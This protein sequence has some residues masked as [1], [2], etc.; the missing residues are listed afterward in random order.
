MLPAPEITT[1]IW[2]FAQFKT[3]YVNKSNIMII[4]AGH[5]WFHYQ[6][7]K[8]CFIWFYKYRYLIL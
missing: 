6:S 1:K 4:K 7:E 2:T 8:F 5:Y 3:H